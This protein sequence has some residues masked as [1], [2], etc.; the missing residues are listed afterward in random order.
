MCVRYQEGLQRVRSVGTVGKGCP[1]IAFA[2][3]CTD[4]ISRCEGRWRSVGEV[5]TIL[6]VSGKVSEVTG[7]L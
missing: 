5:G 2:H 7:G 3:F 4:G 6:M 1:Q